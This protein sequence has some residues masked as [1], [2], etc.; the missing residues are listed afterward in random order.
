MTPPGVRACPFRT[1]RRLVMIARPTGRRRPRVCD[2]HRDAMSAGGAHERDWAL[3]SRGRAGIRAAAHRSASDTLSGRFLLRHAEL[4]QAL[5]APDG[6]GVDDVLP[7]SWASSGRSYIRSSMISSITLRSA[8]APVSR[9]RALRASF[10]QRRGR[11]LQLRVLHLEEVLVLPHHRVLGLGE[12]LHPS[13]SS[14]S[15]ISGVQTGRRPISSGIIPNS[16][17]SSG[18]TSNM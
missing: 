15:G 9:D 6:V 18:V 14:V 12:D 11:E 2:A 8:R 3:D 4:G 1:L 16:I 7:P 5:A 17:R 13:R 10:E